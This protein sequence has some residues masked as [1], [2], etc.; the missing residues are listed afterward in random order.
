MENHNRVDSI[1]WV[2]LG[3]ISGIFR[4]DVRPFL[5]R[6]LDKKSIK[7]DCNHPL[8]RKALNLELRIEAIESIFQERGGECIDFASHLSNGGP[9]IQAG[10]VSFGTES[11]IDQTYY[12]E[13]ENYDSGFY[14][15]ERLQSHL[16]ELARNEI[17]KLYHMLLQPG[18][19]II[20][21]MSSWQSHLPG[22]L[23]SSR[24]TGLGM[25]MK[26]MEINPWLSELVLHDLN[27]ENNLPFDDSCFE[28]VICSLSIEYLSRPVYIFKQIARVLVPGGILIITFFNRW[29]PP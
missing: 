24:V 17:K 23:E 6:E 21:L 3:G 2:T 25:N 16:D 28:A 19:R 14:K 4:S 18:F 11:Y 5:V 9:G 7:I 20:D 1:R 27:Q 22:S 26:E 13:D 8:A 15:T 12:R 29:F 10:L